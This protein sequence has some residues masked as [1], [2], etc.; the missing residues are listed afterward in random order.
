MHALERKDKVERVVE[1]RVNLCM[2]LRK[3]IARVINHYTFGREN[4]ILSSR[5]VSCQTWEEIAKNVSLSSRQVQR[6]C[7]AAMGK[8]SLPKNVI[9]IRNHGRVA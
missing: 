3:Q 6:I 2:E 9:W 7:Y 5:F 8:I 4:F 1:E